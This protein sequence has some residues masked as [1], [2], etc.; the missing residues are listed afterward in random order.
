MA[1][2]RPDDRT[3]RAAA[4]IVL[5]R[6]R[7][8]AATVETP[9][10]AGLRTLCADRPEIAQARLFRADQPDGT[11]YIAII[12]QRSSST[13]GPVVAFGDAARSV[14]LINVYVPYTR[15]S[16]GAFPKGA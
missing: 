3:R 8:A 5:W 14:D 16:V 1:T 10:F 9:I 13:A 4:R 11:D 2:F 15:R 12:E 7:H 6:F